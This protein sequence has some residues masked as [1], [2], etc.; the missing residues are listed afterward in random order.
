M[1][2]SMT[3]RPQ[4]TVSESPLDVGCDDHEQNRN[5]V[6][7][8]PPA[9]VPS[10]EPMNMRIMAAPS[11]AVREV[12]RRIVKAGGSRRLNWKKAI[13]FRRF[14]RQARMRWFQP[15]ARI[16]APPNR[17]MTVVASEPVWCGQAAHEVFRVRFPLQDPARAPELP[18]RPESQ[19]RLR[20]SGPSS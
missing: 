19:G 15:S 7:L 11:R 9:A 10:E 16:S 4:T 14:C 3:F 18:T 8:T 20:K 1:F 5:S 6:V 2:S 13:A 12:C 17:R